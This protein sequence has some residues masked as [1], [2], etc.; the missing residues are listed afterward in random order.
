MIFLH[1]YLLWS[2]PA[3]LLLGTGLHFWSRRIRRRRLA[4]FTTFAETDAML[5][6]R[7]ETRRTVG[8]ALLVL[9]VILGVVALARPLIGPKTVDAEREGIDVLVALDVSKSMLTPDL[10]PRRLE[11]ARAALQHWVRGRAND[12][13]GIILFAGDSFLQIPLTTDHAAVGVM[14]ESANPTGV[15]GSNLENPIRTAIDVFSR[16]NSPSRALILVTDGE[17][18]EDNPVAGAAEAYQ[19]H[20]IRVY[21]LGVGTLAGGKVPNIVQNGRIGG[22]VRNSYGV[23]IYSKLD[24]AML[25]SVATAGGGAYQSL[26]DSPDALQKLQTEQLDRL[27]RET[28]VIEATDYEEWFTL[29]LLLALLCFVAERF[30]HRIVPAGNKVPRLAGAL[31]LLALLLT[32]LAAPSSAKAQV[33]PPPERIPTFDTAHYDKLIK[34]GK[35]AEALS[36]LQKLAELNPTDPFILYN[37][38]VAA[39]VT[40]D[41]DTAIKALETTLALPDEQVRSRALLLA[42]NAHARLGEAKLADGNEAGAAVEFERAL[43]AY[44]NP[45]ADGRG[46]TKNSQ[47]T[48]GVYLDSLEHV[49][50]EQLIYAAKIGDNWTQRRVLQKALGALEQILARAPSRAS[51][52]KRD[53]ETRSLLVGNIVEAGRQK[54][55]EANRNIDAGK[56]KWAYV[57]MR[58]AYEMANSVSNLSPDDP[59]AQS[60]LNDSRTGFSS[61]LVTQGREE[62]EA[63]MKITK[64]SNQ[65]G[66]LGSAEGRA[67]EALSLDPDN[68]QAIT[69]LGEI[70][71]QVE[72]TA[73]LDG[74]AMVEAADKA[75]SPAGIAVN[76]TQAISRFQRVLEVNPNNLHAQ[77]QLAVLIP[78]LAEVLLLM[79][80]A[81]LDTAKQGI[82]ESAKPNAQQIRNALAHLG[83]ADEALAQSSAA[84]MDSQRVQPVLD[85]VHALAEKLQSMLEAMGGGAQ[86]PPPP[87]APKAGDEKGTPGEPEDKPKGDGE[88]EPGKPKTF[89]D[90]RKAGHG[91]R[92]PPPAKDW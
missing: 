64:L 65:L 29:P 31:P 20:G 4:L 50:E 46:L 8:Q 43:D 44:E 3:V 69:L 61:M 14:L 62:F 70:R 72:I 27:L 41:Y 38:A 84:G 7:Q 59:R 33:A 90:I 47:I 36:E 76:L 30:T 40:K 92:N 25:R 48:E 79:G 81:E 73:T 22:E 51:A 24:T 75:K 66:M 6:S 86:P 39:Y 71:A 1:P 78:R 54:L 34:A 60:F 77:A 87:P 57:P 82:P 91:G 52:V 18:H 80:Q 89:S 83:K 15:G 2:L 10:P 16:S 23:G 85:E 32:G 17:N 13:I 67:V 12:R 68:Q 55:A 56:F 53:A 45:S 11:A 9:G 63:A 42:G 49:A 26:G 58:D 74:D 37:L 88:P 35:A 21:T 19:R 28:R 5:R